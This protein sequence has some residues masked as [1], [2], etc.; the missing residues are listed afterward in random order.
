MIVRYDGTKIFPVE[1]ENA[2]TQ[3]PHVRDCAVVGMP[4][5]NHPQS[6]L[7]AAFVTITDSNTNE[8]DIRKYVQE[9]LPIHL[10]P[11]KIHI[12]KQLPV[13]KAGKTDYS[14]LEQLTIDN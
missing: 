14:K 3:H 8:H 10:Q 11:S 2:L 1:I 9:K 4:D 13:T 12:V 7:P 6:L 5:R